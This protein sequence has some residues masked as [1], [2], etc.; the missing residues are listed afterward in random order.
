MK[1]LEEF[2][3]FGDDWKATI[4]AANKDYIIELASKLGK[5]RDKLESSLNELIKDNVKSEDH[6][7]RKL[8]SAQKGRDELKKRKQEWKDESD[9]WYKDFNESQQELQTLK[10]GLQVADI[11]HG[12]DCATHEGIFKECNCG[13]D[14]LKE[15]IKE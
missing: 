2:I 5:E 9:R 14:K 11:R 1:K 13:L 8:L 10:E 12:I 4:K 6:L 7:Y 3:P 15:L